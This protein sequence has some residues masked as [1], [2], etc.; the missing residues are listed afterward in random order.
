M[1]KNGE[2]RF[3]TG[4]AE[5]L[6]RDLGITTLPID[7]FAIARNRKIE[8]CP[9][10][11][12]SAGVS[13]MLIRVGNSFAIGYA[14]HID[15]IPFQR[16]S[17]SHELGHYFLPGHTDA[18]LGDSDVHESHAGFTSSNRYEIEADHFAAGLL[19]PNQL[20]LPALCRAGTG[21]AAIECLAG[22][23]TTSLLATAIRVIECTTGPM[24]IVVSTANKIDYCCMS[25]TFKDI[26]GITWLRKNQPVPRTTP[27]FQ[28]NLEPT[29]V[30]R[31]ART[32]GISNLQEW[33]SSDRSIAITEDVIGLGT[34]GKTLTVLYDI[35]L[36]DEEEE[37]EE[38]SLIESWTPRFRH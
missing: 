23:C 9:K 27:T 37:D 12:S 19:M 32:Q 33:C 34:Y 38:D 15:N 36:L 18:V 5:Q 22:S 2:F 10:P 31:G 1:A 3:A 30:Q 8:V 17:V 28:F 21:L 16:F 14:T 11:S 25:E 13:G 20:F 35:D 24:A 29:K 26:D 4:A 6:I 7:P